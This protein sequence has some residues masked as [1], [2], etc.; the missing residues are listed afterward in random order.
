M[1]RVVR[2]VALGLAIAALGVAIAMPA[3]AATNP[4]SAKKG[5]II[6]VSNC[7]TC[8]ALKAGERARHD[9]PE[10]RSEEALVQADRASRHERQVPDDPVQGDADEDADPGRRR[11]RLQRDARASDQQVARA[12]SGSNRSKSA[13]RPGTGGESRPYC[14]RADRGL[15][16]HWRAVAGERIKLEVSERTAA[17]LRRVPA[18]AQAGHRA[19][20][21]LRPR[22]SRSRSPSASASCVPR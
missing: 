18:P 8:H 10:P 13:G 14:I 7:S 12:P 4:G 6:F 19:G 15:P 3:F 9:R 17:R 21:P 22:R 1:T 20:R 5:K 11:V 16:L 2:R